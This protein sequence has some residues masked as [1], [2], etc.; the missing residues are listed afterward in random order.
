MDYIRMKV[1]FPLTD[2]LKYEVEM[3]VK[4]E[5]LMRLLTVK[6]AN[7]PYFCICCGP[8][9]H[10]E[11]KCTE[12]GEEESK[13]HFGRRPRVSPVKKEA[14]KK[15]YSLAGELKAQK[16]MNLSRVQRD[17]FLAVRHVKNNNGKHST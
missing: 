7:M 10:A 8:L 11:R 16:A 1:C 2:A 14:M 15:F 4:K 12:G 9:G 6:Y 3:C 13:Q 5:G 17:K